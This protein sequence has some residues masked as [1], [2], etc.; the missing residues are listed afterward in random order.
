MN[1]AIAAMAAGLHADAVG[2]GDALGGLD[3]F[4]DSASGDDHVAL[5]LH[6][7]VG[8]HS[9]EDAAANGPDL[10]DAVR[11]I[12]HKDVN[13]AVTNGGVGAYLDGAVLLL[14][15]RGIVHDK[16]HGVAFFDGEPSVQSPLDYLQK[17]SLKK[18]NSGW[19][20]GESKNMGNHV[21]AFFQAAK[22]NDQGTGI[23][24]LR[25]EL[26]GDLSHHT[27]CAFGAD[28]QVFERVASRILNYVG[29]E[30]LDGPVGQ[31]DA[32]AAH[33]I[34][35]ESVADRLHAARVGDDGSADRGVLLAWIRGIEEALLFCGVLH[36]D[37]ERAGFAG[38]GLVLVV[39]GKD[40][41]HAHHGHHDAAV[42]AVGAAGETG[43]RAADND[44]DIVLVAVFH[45]EGNLLLGDDL[46]VELGG[47]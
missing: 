12:G 11:G 30:L 33:K 1:V 10:G 34:P 22:G 37:Q 47:I 14:G 17:L 16:K 3:I 5:L 20:I 38:D 27:E 44:G 8:L 43:A 21:R 29:G 41:V 46:H 19:N 40:F 13:S 25:K 7:R 24:W 26:Q 15:R 39:D 35:C 36:V 6:D 31:D 45:D 23:F 4:R 2:E 42:F 32:D 18:L 28:D 9:V